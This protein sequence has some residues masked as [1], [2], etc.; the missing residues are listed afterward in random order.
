[1]NKNIEKDPVKWM[2]VKF[3]RVLKNQPERIY[4][5][6]SFDDHEFKEINIGK[7]IKKINKDDGTVLTPKYTD[8]LGVSTLKK[9]DLIKLC[10]DGVIPKDHHAFYESLKVSN[11]KKGDVEMVDNEEE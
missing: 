8:V 3:I 7:K 5:K 4:Y 10:K 1:M 2:Q 11:L 6:T 9:N